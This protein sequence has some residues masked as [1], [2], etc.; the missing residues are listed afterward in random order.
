M[1]M[2][3]RVGRLVPMSV[4]VREGCLVPIGV[5]VRV[6]LSTGKAPWGQSHSPHSILPGS[7]DLDLPIVLANRRLGF[8]GGLTETG[9]L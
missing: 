2:P 3:V 1:G 7:S 9:F 5:P 8:C 6:G 4:P